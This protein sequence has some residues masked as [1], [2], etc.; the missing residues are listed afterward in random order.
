MILSSDIECSVT[1]E[2]NVIWCVYF[3]TAYSFN[4]VFQFSKM[5]G[6]TLHLTKEPLSQYR[7]Y[8][9]TI[10]I[11]AELQSDISSVLCRSDDDGIC[12]AFLIIRISRES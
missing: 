6:N 11:N 10:K 12:F 9:Y 7:T 2:L 1:F 5:F 8:L 3:V 4:I